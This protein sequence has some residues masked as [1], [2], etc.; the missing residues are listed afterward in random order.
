MPIAVIQVV[1]GILSHSV[2]LRGFALLLAGPLVL[3][4]LA[5]RRPAL[6]VAGVS[7]VTIGYLA[8][9]YPLGPIAL[10]TVVAV[11]YAVT[12][13]ARLAA[14]LS[15]GGLYLGWLALGLTK[16]RELGT[17]W[18]ELRWLGLALLIAGFAELIDNRSQ[19]VAAYRKLYAE[20]R[21]RREEQERLRIA[22]ELHD[23]LAHSLSLIAVR[24]SVALELIDSNP[25]EVRNALLA[26]KQ[27]S[28]GGLDE[29]RSV[30]HGLREDTAPRAPA[31]SLDRLDELI[32]DYP[33]LSVTLNRTG[34]LTELPA[35]A[36]L[37]AYRIVQEALTNVIRHSQARKAV[38]HLHNAGWALLVGVSDDGPSTA[39]DANE[40]SGLIGIRERAL[41]LGGVAETGPDPRGGFTVHVA[42]P[43]PGGKR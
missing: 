4:L 19:R 39:T 8:L 42:L 15:L 36:G 2:D 38:V 28:K 35:A 33:G 12:H 31:P 1:A 37:A 14:W 30:L 34:P 5:Y 11:V 22:R 3:L 18:Q 7:A 27:A 40:G 6:A 43:L 20:E 26:I 41:S 32:A 21:R 10:S 23:V 29:V 13:S 25:D 9:G 16:V 17:I 24:A